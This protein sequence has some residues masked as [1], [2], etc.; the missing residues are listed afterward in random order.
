MRAAS[1]RM[2][3]SLTTDTANGFRLQRDQ[4]EKNIY[5]ISEEKK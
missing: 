1:L 5:S 4:W 2:I 3:F